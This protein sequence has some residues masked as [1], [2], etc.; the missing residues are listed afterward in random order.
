MFTLKSNTV[1]FLLCLYQPGAT[2]ISYACEW[3]AKHGWCVS[4][5]C[6]L[7]HITA[8][9]SKERLRV[10]CERSSTGKSSKSR[11]EVLFR[12]RWSACFSSFQ[13]VLNHWDAHFSL[14]SQW[15]SSKGPCVYGPAS[16]GGRL[17]LR[18]PKGQ[19]E[20][21]QPCNGCDCPPGPQ[22]H[23]PSRDL[24]SSTRVAPWGRSICPAI[25]QNVG[26]RWTWLGVETLVTVEQKQKSLNSLRANLCWRH[27]FYT[28][29]SHPPRF[30]SR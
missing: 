5:M 27:S 3:C 22:R 23:F 18:E 12:W 7:Q 25:L 13:L 24:I 19:S 20:P 30:V 10:Y 26:F 11:T 1:K 16:W 21:L 8:D 9:S 14:F 17:Q 28:R 6:V 15:C 29:L 2:V 4:S